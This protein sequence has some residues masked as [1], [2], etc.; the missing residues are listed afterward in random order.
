MSMMITVGNQ[1]D[2]DGNTVN[3]NEVFVWIKGRQCCGAYCLGVS[4][5]CLMLYFELCSRSVDFIHDNVCGAMHSMNAICIYTY[6]I[7]NPP[8]PNHQTRM[9]AKRLVHHSLTT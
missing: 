2:G 7:Y 5:R 3:I 9:S 8:L 1:P 4:N 6:I